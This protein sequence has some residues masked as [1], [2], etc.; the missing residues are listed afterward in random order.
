MPTEPYPGMPK[1]AHKPWLTRCAL[2]MPDPPKVPILTVWVEGN[3]V[4]ALLDSGST[5]TLARL[6]ILPKTVSRNGT[7]MV[8]CIHGDAREVPATKVQIQGRAGTWPLLVG[9]IPDLPV[10]LLMAGDWP[11][12][13]ASPAPKIRRAPQQT[14]EARVWQAYIVYPISSVFQQMN[15][16]GSFRQ[17][18]PPQELLGT[19]VSNQRCRPESGPGTPLNLLT[20]QERPA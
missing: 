18:R 20:S 11:G 5:V 14:K 6:T 19:G 12:F 17:E 10:P 7:I 3:P 15:Q 9:V 2:Y 13:P 4:T 1:K 16:Q 8:T